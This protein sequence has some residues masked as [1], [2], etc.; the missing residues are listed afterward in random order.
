MGRGHTSGTTLSRFGLIGPGPCQPLSLHLP[1]RKTGSMPVSVSVVTRGVR[2]QTDTQ[3]ER[4]DIE[5]TCSM[6]RT[7][8]HAY[9][10][11]PTSSIPKYPAALLPDSYLAIVPRFGLTRSRSGGGGSLSHPSATHAGETGWI[12][13]TGDT[14]ALNP[15]LVPAA[16]QC[17]MG[18][19]TALFVRAP[20][21]CKNH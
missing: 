11:D 18:C 20:R 5:R 10:N 3:G 4:Y 12:G 13:K 9:R 6:R 21:G 2:R 16:G 7:Y 1:C 17:R 8:G 15:L 19:A 14:A